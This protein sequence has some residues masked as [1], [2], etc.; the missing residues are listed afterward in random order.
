MDRMSSG[1]AIS[2]ETRS[3]VSRGATATVRSIALAGIAL[4]ELT[5]FVLV[6]TAGSLIGVGLGLFLLPPLVIVVQGLMNLLRTLAN[7]WSGVPIAVPYVAPPDERTA[8]SPLRRLHHLLG[9]RANWR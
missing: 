9:D 3:F 8:R 7:D 6:V 5:L 1:N 4:I 2:T